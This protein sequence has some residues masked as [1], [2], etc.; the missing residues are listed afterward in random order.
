MSRRGISQQGPAWHRNVQCREVSSSRTAFPED[1]IQQLRLQ[2]PTDF[3]QNAAA[4]VAIEGWWLILHSRLQRFTELIRQQ[5]ADVVFNVFVAGHYVD[6]PLLPPD[7][8][9]DRQHEETYRRVPFLLLDQ[10]VDAMGLSF[11]DAPQL[12][13]QLSPPAIAL[14]AQFCFEF[15]NM[16]CI[17]WWWFNED[18]NRRLMCLPARSMALLEAVARQRGFALVLAD[19]HGQ[20]LPQLQ[21]P[22][23]P[24]Q[25]VVRE[26][27]DN[28][29]NDHHNEEEAAIEEVVA[30]LGARFVPDHDRP[31]RRHQGQEPEPVAMLQYIVYAQNLLTACLHQYAPHYLQRLE[32]ELMCIVEHVLP[33]ANADNQRVEGGDQPQ[34]PQRPQQQQQP[35]QQPRDA[36]DG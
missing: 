31:R 23:P 22:P 10:L 9:N 19:G 33:A 5:A 24:P 3:E 15:C 11:E 28:N 7:Y 35:E 13:L 29:N 34:Q 18:A 25:A 26:E 8:P 20:E 32:L 16:L 14:F 6:Y 12:Q 21:P 1:I 4:Y 2:P 27:D 30:F 17:F 36:L